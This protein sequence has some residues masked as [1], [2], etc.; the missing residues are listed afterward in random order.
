MAAPDARTVH[1]RTTNGAATTVITSALRD[2]AVFVSAGLP[3]PPAGKSYQLWFDDH[4]TMRP[5]G[6]LPGDGSTVMQGDRGS[7][8]A[9]GL[10]LEPAG[11]S[12]QP[13]TSPLLLLALPA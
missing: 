6:L 13:T 7:A 8:R 9:V 2:K 10:T 1:G 11:G 4:G 3:T 12:P 5:A